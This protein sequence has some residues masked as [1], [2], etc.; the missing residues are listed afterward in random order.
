MDVLS[1]VLKAVEFDRATFHHAECLTLSQR[2]HSQPSAS[3][4]AYKTT[5]MSAH[6]DVPGLSVMAVSLPLNSVRSS[7]LSARSVT[8]YR[9]G[10]GSP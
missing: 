7:P 5:A 3:A 2:P 10:C 9:N 4:I 8:Y 1:D 6:S